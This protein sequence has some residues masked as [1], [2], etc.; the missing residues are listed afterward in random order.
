MVVDR[1]YVGLSPEP[2]DPNNVSAYRLALL[3]TLEA[4]ECY[5]A[6][7]FQAD[8]ASTYP[9]PGEGGLVPNALAAAI[10]RTLQALRKHLQELSKEVGDGF[11]SVWFDRMY[12]YTHNELTAWLD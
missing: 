9:G 10:L 12:M 1:L 11:E 8:L 2:T 3:Q 6:G 5:L 7:Y 4:P